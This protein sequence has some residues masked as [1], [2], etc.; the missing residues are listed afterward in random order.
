MPFAKTAPKNYGD[1]VAAYALRLH[2]AAGEQ[3]HVISPLGAWLLVAL[4]APLASGSGRERLENVLGCNAETARR[5]ADEMLENPHPALAL[6][7]AAWYRGDFGEGLDAWRRALPPCATTGSMPTQ[8][9][10]NAWAREQTRGQIESMP[11]QIS[12]DSRLLLA[13]AVATEVQWERAFDLVPAAELG[14]PWATRV[15]RVMRRHQE[16]N[17]SVVA[18]TEAAG[19]VG[20]SRECG[21][22]GLDVISVI[23]APDVQPARVIAAAYDIAALSAGL[24]STAA[25]INAFDLPITGHAWVVRERVL[26]NFRG[27]Q[28]IEKSEVTIP[29]WIA[30][31]KL[32][33]LIAAP[34]TGLAEIVRAILGQLPPDPRGDGAGATQVARARFDTNGFSAAA[35][36]IVHLIGSMMPPPPRQVIERTVE[37][38]FDRPFA[39]VAATNADRIS[40]EGGVLWRGLPAFGA[41]VTEPMEPSEPDETEEDWLS[42]LPKES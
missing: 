4:T 29:A 27:P 15:N 20:V 23:A 14:G 32:E 1:L 10:A 11:V 26:T 31:T 12:D 21:R 41:W 28:R 37:V 30:E 19:F 7:F 17:L 16:G 24:P 34:G 2:A 9:E 18:H 38:R 25:F 36:T 22:G 8:A 42:N 33:D 5:A 3:H 40:G 6:A 35:L 13:T 39:V